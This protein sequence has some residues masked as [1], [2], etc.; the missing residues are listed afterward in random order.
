MHTIRKDLTTMMKDAWW[1]LDIVGLLMN[2]FLLCELH[3]N[4]EIL[5]TK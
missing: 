1:Y 2:V 3:M 5:D 4:L